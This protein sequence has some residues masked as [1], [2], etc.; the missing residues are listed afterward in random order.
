MQACGPARDRDDGLPGAWVCRV[1]EEGGAELW[2][3]WLN[4]WSVARFLGLLSV[5]TACSRRLARARL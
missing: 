4:T 5:A 1:E 3:K 2:G